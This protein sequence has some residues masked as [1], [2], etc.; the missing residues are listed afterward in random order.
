M[1]L[2][3]VYWAFVDLIGLRLALTE[4]DGSALVW[5]GQLRRDGF[6]QANLLPPRDLRRWRDFDGLGPIAF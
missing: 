4:L 5:R 2:T 1:V 3:G 6:N